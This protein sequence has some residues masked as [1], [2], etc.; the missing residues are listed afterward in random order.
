MCGKFQLRHG[1]VA[2]FEHQKKKRRVTWSFTPFWR[3][4]I[5]QGNLQT[6]RWKKTTKICLWSPIVENFAAPSWR[7][8]L[9]KQ[10][11]TDRKKNWSPQKLTFFKPKKWRW[12]VFWWF[13][14]ETEV[15]IS[16]SISAVRFSGRIFKRI[17]PQNHRKR[18]TWDFWVCFLALIRLCHL[19][20]PFFGVSFTQSLTKPNS[21]FGRVWLVFRDFFFVSRIHVFAQDLPKLPRPMA[22]TSQ[23]PK[24]DEPPNVKSQLMTHQKQNINNRS[25]AISPDKKSITEIRTMNRQHHPNKIHKH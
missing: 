22:Q 4:P 19:G 24:K 2:N 6:P 17:D 25:I 1:L 18:G 11:L 23:K 13:S 14:L 9:T 3:P 12:M 7:D 5:F 10:P 8:S 15:K 16:G 20:H 21:R